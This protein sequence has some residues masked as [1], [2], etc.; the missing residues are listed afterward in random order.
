MSGYGRYRLSIGLLI[1]LTSSLT[2]SSCI[3]LSL[4]SA[5]SVGSLRRNPGRVQ[6][7]LSRHFTSNSDNDMDE[8]PPPMTNLYQEWTLDQDKLLW[9]RRKESLPALASLLWSRTARRR[10]ETRQAVGR[11]KSGISTTVLRY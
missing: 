7:L 1:M 3:S 4:V 11:R 9:E 10:I 5:F 8:S 2:R 6:S